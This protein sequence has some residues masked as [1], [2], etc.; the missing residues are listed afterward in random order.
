[1]VDHLESRGV[2]VPLYRIRESRRARR[3]RIMVLDP[4]TVEVVVPE[5]TSAVWIEGFVDQHRAW[6][7][8]RLTAIADLPR[9]GLDRSDVAWIGGLPVPRPSGN[10]SRWYRNRARSALTA[11][12]ERE[13]E[14]LDLTGWTRIRVGDPRGRWGSCSMRGTLSF[15]WRLVMTPPEVLAYV[16]V[17]ELCHLRH[18]NHSTRFWELL[19]EAWPTR[20]E[21]QAWLRRHGA[22][23]HS[24]VPPTG[25]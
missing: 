18:M 9:L 19:D 13:S 12:I 17:H 6:I 3:A 11:V 16:V 21:Q 15:S 2:E 24:Y 14:R 4:G 8:A 5:G 10:L 20:R 23:L 1:M 7:D 25:V 22:E